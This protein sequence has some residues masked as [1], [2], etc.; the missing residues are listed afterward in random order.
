MDFFA[1]TYRQIHAQIA[2]DLFG[3]Y[4]EFARNLCRICAQRR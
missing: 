4:S 3:I 1:K 2:P